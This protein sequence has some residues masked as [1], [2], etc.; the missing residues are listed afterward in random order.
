MKGCR[1]K[2]FEDFR[3]E[4]LNFLQV[5]FRNCEVGNFHQRALVEPLAQEASS[6]EFSQFSAVWWPQT[7]GVLGAD[8]CSRAEEKHNLSEFQ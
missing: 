6:Y 2:P 4:L 8:G 7:V 1:A 5:C 3:D